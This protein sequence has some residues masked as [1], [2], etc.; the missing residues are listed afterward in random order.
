MCESIIQEI[1]LPIAMRQDLTPHSIYNVPNSLP[2]LSISLEASNIP[3]LN[4][5][6]ALLSMIEIMQPIC[7]QF[8]QPYPPASVF[9][10]AL[11]R[12]T[13]RSS[14]LPCGALTYNNACTALRGLA[15]FMTLSNQFFQWRFQIWVNGYALGRGRIDGILPR[16]PEASAAGVATS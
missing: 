16:L 8:M 4:P 14:N 11:I 15:E 3:Q 10:Y 13:I 12:I 5:T 9:D 7:R 6:I 2:P 1:T